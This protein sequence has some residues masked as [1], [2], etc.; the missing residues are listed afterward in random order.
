M[1][2]ELIKALRNCDYPNCY[3]YCSQGCIM[4]PDGTATCGKTPLLRKAADALT[5]LQRKL[6]K[7]ESDNINLTGW[8]AAEH[9][10]HLW[11]PVTERL[12][13]KSGIYLGWMQWDL[14]DPDD[15]PGVYQIE[16]DEVGG[17]FGWW[18][19]YFDPESLGLAGEDFIQYE[20]VTHWMQLPEPPKEG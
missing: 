8:L 15:T 3:H 14:T 18:R 13:E 12:P 1:Y 11:I 5:E 19:S 20:G 6:M 10:K 9:A 17:A 16:Y 7:S 2:E 4:S